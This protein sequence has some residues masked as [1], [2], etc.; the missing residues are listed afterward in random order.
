MYPYAASQ[1]IG[2]DALKQVWKLYGYGTE[3]SGSFFVA[4][5]FAR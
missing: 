2:R 5:K 3:Y 4:E 1:R